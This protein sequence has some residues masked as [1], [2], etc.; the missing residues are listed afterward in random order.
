M[1]TTQLQQAR[2]AH[3]IPI[4]FMVGSQMDWLSSDFSDS[5]TIVRTRL[6]KDPEEAS[7]KSSKQL[8]EEKYETLEL[9]KQVP[10]SVFTTTEKYLIVFLGAISGFWSSISSPIYLP[11]LPILQQHFGVSEEQMNAT[12]VVYSVFQ[13]LSPVLFS[14]LADVVGRRTV[15][16]CCLTIY[17]TANIGLALNETFSGLLCLRCLQAFGIAP[18]LSVS[19]GIASDITTK[20]ERASFIGLSTGLSL[21]GQA[22]GALIGGMVST[23]FGWRAIFWFLAIFSGATWVLVYACLPETTRSI[24]GNGSVVPKGHQWVNLAP[25]LR[26][27]LFQK[28]TGT[29]NTVARAQPFDMLSPFRILGR[30]PVYLVLT[31]SSLCYALW[32]MMLTTL[33]TQLSRTYGYSTL[34]IALE[35]IPSGIGGLLGSI[36]SGKLL[37]W[38]YRRSYRHFV[39]RTNKYKEDSSARMAANYPRFN[40]FRA[41]LFLAVIP[42][43]TTVIGALLFGWAIQLHFSVVWVFIGLFLVSYGAMNYLTLST[44]VLVDLFPT[45]SSGSSLCVNLTRCWCAAVGITFLSRMAAAMTVG[46]CY[47]FMAGLVVVSGGCIAYVLVRSE[48]WV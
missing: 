8:S 26:M 34:Q 48:E 23:A 25:V 31:P 22:F 12:V 20:A 17:I 2:T 15:I 6:Q 24:V 36:T 32:L 13:G 10:H 47:S 5:A 1:T 46:W 42:T 29:T 18:T 45:H 21:L 9:Q 30:T 35:Y 11:V 16:L 3:N 39:D 43:G 40:I 37:D 41:R 4:Q 28:R 19:S 14:N 33:S 44:T 27:A 7:W 38:H